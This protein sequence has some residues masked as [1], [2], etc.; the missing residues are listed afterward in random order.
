MSVIATPFDPRHTAEFR[1]RLRRTCLP[2]ALEA[3]TAVRGVHVISGASGS[4]PDGYSFL[5]RGI[6]RKRKVRYC[7]ERDTNITRYSR[8]LL[9][10][11]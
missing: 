5:R 1:G 6:A 11:H 10:S 7:A 4:E 3:P 2:R 8:D 9:P